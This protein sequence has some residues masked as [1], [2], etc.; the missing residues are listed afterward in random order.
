VTALVAILLAPFAVLTAFFV[1]EVLA[2]LP[3]VAAARR[4]GSR[5]SAVIVV[6]AHD[7]EAVIGDTLGR[8]TEVLGAGMQI[9]VVAD[10]CTDSTAE[11]ARLPGVGVVE[12]N[13]PDLRG[14]G[15]ALAFAVE[16]LAADPPDVLVVLDAD[17][18][19]D[20]ASLQAL[21]ESAA[22]SGRPSQAINLL[23]P[24]RTAS[25][26]VQLSSFAFMLKNLV[27]QRGL[28]R[29]AGRVHLTGTGMAMPF[30]LFRASAHV[31][32]SIVEDLALGLDLA[33]QGHPPQLVEDAFVWS[34]GSTEQGTLI[35][36]RRWE[37]GFLATAVRYGL[38]ATLG[39]N[40]IAGLDLL[41]PP[42]ALFA[43]LSLAALVI[44]T[45]LTLAFD[46]AW[47]PIIVQASLL[48]VAGFAV[49]LAW[50]RE[51][52]RFVSL[53]VL[54]RVPLYILWKLPMYFGLARRGAPGE[55]L[56]TG[57]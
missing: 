35:Q 37:G 38:K 22:A 25:P 51:G 1:M 36:R 43:A 46:L 5:F 53:G 30:S 34:G 55:W 54:A 8:L 44:A 14:K 2:G 19:I 49:F 33:D 18:T 16:R 32:S 21:V 47:W 9:L 3:A 39:G 24:D 42:L 12:R 23:H 28:Q 13:D 57:R 10:N 29:L 27:R 56:R 52:R 6:P 50:L 48:A 15:H 40:I 20:E 31:R 17:C 45:F 41:V 7:E 26:L 4:T 11:R